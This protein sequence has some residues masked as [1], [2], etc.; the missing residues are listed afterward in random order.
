MLKAGCGLY[1]SSAY[2]AFTEEGLR[3][4]ESE[5]EECARL[6]ELGLL[7]EDLIREE[8]NRQLAIEQYEELYRREH[9]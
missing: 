2:R 1:K 6:Y 5:C 4:H 9:S 7:E 3:K 8:A